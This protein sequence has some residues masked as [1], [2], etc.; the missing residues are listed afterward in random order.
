MSVRGVADMRK[1]NKL[2]SG[3]GLNIWAAAAETRVQAA[4]TMDA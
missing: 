1:P 3:N 2:P 4:D